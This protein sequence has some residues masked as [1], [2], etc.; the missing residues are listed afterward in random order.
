[1]SRR[2]L[3]LCLFLIFI[4]LIPVLGQSVNVY[5]AIRLD[6]DQN[7]LPSIRVDLVDASTLLNINSTF[8]NSTGGYIF[9]NVDTQGGTRDIYATAVSD[10]VLA[11]VQSLPFNIFYTQS[12][13]TV[14]NINS[15]TELNIQI[16]N[17]DAT[18]KAFKIYY[19]IFQ[20]YTHFSEILGYNP[21]T[22]VN[23]KYPSPDGTTQYFNTGE[24]LW[25]GQDDELF[26]FVVHEYGHF[27]MDQ[28]YLVDPATFVTGCPSGGT[29]PSTAICRQRA[30]EEGWG[31]FVPST[32]NN[33]DLGIISTPALLETGNFNF[34]N[35]PN[36]GFRLH[37]E[38]SGIF[39]DIADGLNSTDGSI[40]TDDDRIYNKDQ[41]LWDVLV[42]YPQSQKPTDI[43]QFY[44]RWVEKKDYVEYKNL[45]NELYDIYYNH[46]I[47]K[48]TNNEPVTNDWTYFL[49][50]PRIKRKNRS[51][52][53]YL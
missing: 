22:I 1:M 13:S 23:V 3:L 49:H 43:L 25:V 8:T 14:N 10:S 27:I 20:A 6:S 11:K 47:H 41:M 30:F 53:V 38:I 12:S 17:N 50:D 45:Q 48:G 15:N 35:V 34:F 24:I 51:V 31:D 19:Y 33:T 26:K 21:S 16:N 52:G 2:F 44:N 40:G 39:W 7:P 37:G 18:E 32:T 28:I 9:I 42:D 46:F 36:I 4:H 5:G 29:F